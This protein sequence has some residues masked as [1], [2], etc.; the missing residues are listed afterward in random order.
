M[1]PSETRY[2]QKDRIAR[3]DCVLGEDALLLQGLSGREAVSEP[4][5]FSLELASQH[6]SIELR[7]L[8][9]TP[10]GITIR[11][12]NGTRRHLHGIV[13]RFEHVGSDGRLCY[14]RAAIVPWLWLL[15]QR[16]DSRIFQDRSVP[17]IVGEVFE[18]LADSDFLD[19]TKEGYP[20]R[21]YCV[22]YRETDFNFVSRL[23]E[24]A[25]IGYY[26]S[27]EEKRHQLVLF[28][29][30]GSLK[31]SAQ[32]SAVYSGARDLG[33][34][35]S[36]WSWRETESLRPGHFALGD[37]DFQQPS[38]D[39]GVSAASVDL[40]A[41]DDSLELYDFPGRYASI[42]EGAERV[43][44]WSQR[45]EAD[46]HRAFSESDCAHFAAGTWFKLE[47]H[48][49]PSLVRDYL[50]T[51]VE[52]RLE[53]PLTTGNVTAAPYS[54]RVECIPKSLPYRP[55][56][57]AR[58]PQ[59]VGVQSAVVVGPPGKELH[60]DRLGRVKLKFH[61]D[62]APHRDETS[63]CWVRVSQPWAGRRWGGIHL[64]RIGQEVIVDFIDG[65]P[66]RPIVTG[67]LYN[68]EQMP[69]YPLPES[70]HI[71]GFKTASQPGSSGHNE[72]AFE[73]S[74]GHEL[75]RLRAQRDMQTHVENDQTL[76]VG[77]N[78]S[79]HVG[80]V[81][82]LTGDARIEIVAGAST[83]H[84]DPTRMLLE[85]NGNTILIDAAG[86]FINGERVSSS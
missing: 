81:Y 9:G 57:R 86:V 31:R 62:R 33:R 19:Q 77:N 27:H 4:F 7:S 10:M 69:P 71:S 80:Q 68:A 2:R 17:E 12:E 67:R 76:V 79:E 83:I 32:G 43:R 14:Y 65:D 73:D 5:E 34:R 13:A 8:I 18:G 53:Q 1:K 6:P 49:H 56:L 64:P 42:S 39:L 52:H 40:K 55:P 75:L 48:P 61:W 74:R 46:A 59:V 70:A 35:G 15:T 11:V 47:G 54:N 66:D 26:F 60:V 36:I 78:R 45:S 24:E 16:Y 50:L 20:R 30:N 37:Y 23:L 84:L 3:I 41:T 82:R 21:D 25:G 72:L 44:T 63:S 28:D 38:T 51:A 58:K 22:Q 29:H 85:S